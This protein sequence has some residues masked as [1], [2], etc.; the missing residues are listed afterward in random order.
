M[1]GRGERGALAG[2]SGLAWRG[3]DRGGVLTLVRWMCW[4]GNG[5][6]EAVEQILVQVGGAQEG[7]GRMVLVVAG[8]LLVG[9]WV[10]G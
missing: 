5:F 4:P 8:V 9:G 7:G 3:G 6:T 1:L 2:A 10:G